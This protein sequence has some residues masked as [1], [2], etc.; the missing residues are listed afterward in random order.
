MTNVYDILEERGYI[1]QSTDPGIRDLLGNESVTFYVGFDPTAE[2]CTWAI[3]FK[4]W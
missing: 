2:A 3:S 4:L 1:E